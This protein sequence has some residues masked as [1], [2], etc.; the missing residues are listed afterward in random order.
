LISYGGYE[1]NCKTK[2]SFFPKKLLQNIFFFT[3]FIPNIFTFSHTNQFLRYEKPIKTPQ[4]FY[5]TEPSCLDGSMLAI[6][7]KYLS[8]G[9]GLPT[10]TSS[11]NKN[12]AEEVVFKRMLWPNSCSLI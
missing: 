12:E 8:C 1:A 9:V 2:F 11:S 10:S 5:Q 4:G 6:D 3:F 7:P